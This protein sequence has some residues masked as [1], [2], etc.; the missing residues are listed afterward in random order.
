MQ[1]RRPR[2][3]RS[4]P[5]SAGEVSALSHLLVVAKLQARTLRIQI[6]EE[7]LA[8]VKARAK[9]SCTTTKGFR[10]S[11][12]LGRGLGTLK[13][14]H[15]RACRGTGMGTLASEISAD[16][17]TRGGGLRQR[18]RRRLRRCEPRSE[19]GVAVAG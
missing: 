14:N 3:T 10:T 17:R 15:H 2:S 6:V 18:G 9:E 12:I 8:P 11:S 7:L 1:R 19:V 16:I 13:I 5:S 4:R